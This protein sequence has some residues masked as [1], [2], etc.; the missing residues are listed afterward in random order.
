ML[1]LPLALEI[2][3]TLMSTRPRLACFLFGISVSCLMDCDSLMPHLRGQA[4][5]GSHFIR[6]WPLLACRVIGF[7]REILPPFCAS[8]IAASSLARLGNP[9]RRIHIPQDDAVIDAS[10][11]HH[12]PIGADGHTVDRSSM[13]DE[14]LADGP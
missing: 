12:P 11:C 10:G 3:P 13:L 9:R 5:A 1:T 14:R 2:S 6:H 7:I 4:G 8:E